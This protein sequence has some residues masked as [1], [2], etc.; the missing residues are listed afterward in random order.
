[1]KIV[2]TPP[3]SSENGEAKFNVILAPTVTEQTMPSGLIDGINY[4]SDATK[5]TLVLNAPGKDFI[6][7]A[8]SFNNYTPTST[9]LMKKDPGT[10]KFWLELTNLTSG[11]IET[12]QYWVTQTCLLSFYWWNNT[13]RLY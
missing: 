5:A 1:M 13:W 11:Q 7:V 10:G 9:Y 3:G 2:G 12:Y 6:E 8:G 4:T